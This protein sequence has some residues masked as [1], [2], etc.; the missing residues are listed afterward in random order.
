[1][2]K[3]V[4]HVLAKAEEA[5]TTY[6]MKSQREILLKLYASHSVPCNEKVLG[7]QETDRLALS[8]AEAV[9]DALHWHPLIWALG[10]TSK[11]LRIALF[12]LDEF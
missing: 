10:Q 8:A 4:S 9:D 11:K 7:Y 1:M 3:R 2:D 5:D 6:N 12:E